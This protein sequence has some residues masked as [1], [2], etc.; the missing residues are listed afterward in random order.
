VITCRLLWCKA[1]CNA[2]RWFTTRRALQQQTTDLSR[3]VAIL[4][5]EGQRL[6]TGRPGGNVGQSGALAL[7]AP[8]GGA[9]D[10][11]AVITTRLVEFKDIQVSLQTCI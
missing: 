5:N 2:T 7:M 6:K 10:A 3:Q 1:E 11:Q 8:P 9:V 4:L